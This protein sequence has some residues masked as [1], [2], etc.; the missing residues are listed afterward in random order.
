MS[1]AAFCTY[2]QNFDTSLLLV[3]LSMPETWY[4]VFDSVRQSMHLKTIEV[5]EISGGFHSDW[6]RGRWS[7]FFGNLKEHLL[8]DGPNPFSLEQLSL[9]EDKRV[10]A[11]CKMR[12]YLWA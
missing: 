7:D 2:R 5:D 12:G 10:M 6:H 11:Q 9:W 1:Y 4:E 8:Q 3:I